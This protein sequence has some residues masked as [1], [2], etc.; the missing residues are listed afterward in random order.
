MPSGVG[1]PVC[2]AVD[3]GGNALYYVHYSATGATSEVR[4]FAYDCNG[5]GIGDD[6]DLR[7]GTSTDLN[8][9]GIPDKCEPSPACAGE[10]NSDGV[11]DPLDSGYV[12]SRFGGAVGAGDADCDAAGQKADGVVDPL[13]AGFVLSR[14]GDCSSHGKGSLTI[15]PSNRAWTVPYALPG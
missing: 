11:V 13:D 15:Q 7:S 14:F 1:I 6:E 9:N 4:R 5:N 12:P 2:L 3:P 10:S 8:G